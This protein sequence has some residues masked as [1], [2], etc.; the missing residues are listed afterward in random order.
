MKYTV[1]IFSLFLL[2]AVGCTGGKAAG[3][4]TPDT[5]P[6]AGN[7]GKVDPGTPKEVAPAGPSSD[8]C[9]DTQ[10]PGVVH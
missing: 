3:K 7:T 1:L 6:V 10:C 9:T 5:D 8:L 4:T 2:L